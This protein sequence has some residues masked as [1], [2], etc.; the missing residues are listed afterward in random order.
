MGGECNPKV[1]GSCEQALSTAFDALRRLPPPG[2]Y[3]SHVEVERQ[4]HATFYP[5]ADDGDLLVRLGIKQSY[6]HH[7]SEICHPDEQPQTIDFTKTRGPL[8]LMGAVSMFGNGDDDKWFGE[9]FGHHMSDAGMV[10]VSLTP[11]RASTME[12]AQRLCPDYSPLR[13]V[14]AKFYRDG[15]WSDALERVGDITRA[16]VAGRK[17][18][19]PTSTEVHFPYRDKTTRYWGACTSGAV[20]VETKVVGSMPTHVPS[21]KQNDPNATKQCELG[22]YWQSMTYEHRPMVAL[23]GSPQGLPKDTKFLCVRAL[24]SE[25]TP[26]LQTAISVDY[27]R[28]SGGVLLH[29]DALDPRNVMR[30]YGYNRQQYDAWRNSL[31]TVALNWQEEERAP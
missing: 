14:T 23:D 22:A 31:F 6:P 17:Q 27:L 29:H 15:P 8:I 16:V 1:K 5:P 28:Q 12:E 2:S 25:P 13:N 20:E 9:W 18:T 26:L 4:C 10:Y 24:E 3:P 7:P 21:E 19:V 30:T 11:L